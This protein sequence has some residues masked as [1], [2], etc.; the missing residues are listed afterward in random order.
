MAELGFQA[1]PND[2]QEQSFDPV[3]A[4]SY[5]VIIEDSD[6]VDNKKQNGKK[7]PPK[8]PQKGTMGFTGRQKS[9]HQLPLHISI[10]LSYYKSHGYQKQA[11]SGPVR[12]LRYYRTEAGCTAGAPGGAPVTGLGV[13]P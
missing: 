10:L 12:S 2:A 9:Q 6:Y 13:F 8:R 4:G 5:P 11:H 1:D 3:P 7:S